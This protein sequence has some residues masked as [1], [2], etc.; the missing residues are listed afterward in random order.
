MNTL[1]FT[2]NHE[3]T[4][5]DSAEEIAMAL[6]CCLEND[7]RQTRPDQDP[8]RFPLLL[9]HT[10]AKG[11]V[12]ITL[13]ELGE[14]NLHAMAAALQTWDT[15]AAATCQLAWGM[16]MAESP[17]G[18]RSCSEPAEIALVTAVSRDGDPVVRAGYLER[19]PNQ[20]PVIRRWEDCPC[21]CGATTYLALVNGV[22]PPQ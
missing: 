19:R 9:A 6:Q 15:H 16:V 20:N 11:R 14:L 2:T 7:L 3:D 18:R 13:P 8:E 10:A 5:W 12:A 4:D 17:S 21:V 1:T 22:C